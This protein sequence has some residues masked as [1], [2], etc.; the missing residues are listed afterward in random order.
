MRRGLVTS[1]LVAGLALFLSSCVFFPAAFQH[2]QNM[3]DTRP[4]WCHS[5]GDGG[6]NHGG[7][8]PYE[9]VEKGMLSWDDCL[10]VSAQFDLATD[11][12]QQWQT[13]GEAEDDGWHQVVG[14]A[15]GMGTHH[16]QQGTFDPSYL[17]SP[18]FD[19]DDP[20]FPGTEW[21]EKFD[22]TK[23]EFLMYDGN[24][25]NAQL[26]GMAWWVRTTDGQ[27]PEGFPGDNDWWHQHP[28]VCVNKTNVT[29]MGENRP[30]AECE[31]L[32]G[33]NVDF[34]KYWMAHAWIIDPWHVQ[35]D[36]FTNHHPCL[37]GAG[38]IFDM[39]DECW[40]EAMSGGG[41]GGH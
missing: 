16:S 11:Y 32:G 4:W 21:D 29:Y 6:H 39:N 8:N 14:Y 22:P 38:P 12:V 17:T 36:V 27:P 10:A 2:Q 37:S 3:P 13:E 24:G 25:R 15:A 1:G 30:D 33:V 41:H 19:P 31:S 35:F 20:E 40:D 7:H 23:P 28:L 9:G 18:E 34:S 26:T 5:T